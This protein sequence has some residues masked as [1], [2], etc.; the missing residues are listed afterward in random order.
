MSA[1]RFSNSN[2]K[3]HRFLGLLLSALLAGEIG[4]AQGGL[5]AAV[6]SQANTDASAQRRLQDTAKEAQRQRRI[7]DQRRRLSPALSPEKLAGPGGRMLTR[8][9][10]AARVRLREDGVPLF[11]AILRAT[12]TA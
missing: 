12:R 2:P 3:P 11:E 8:Q 10:L 9:A 1:T 5:P 4:H 6:G 7:E